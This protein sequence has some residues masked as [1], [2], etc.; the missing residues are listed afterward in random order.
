[1]GGTKHVQFLGVGLQ[2][3]P[4]KDGTKIPLIVEFMIVPLKML[5]FVTLD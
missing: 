4:I 2:L 1:M 3:L 5:G